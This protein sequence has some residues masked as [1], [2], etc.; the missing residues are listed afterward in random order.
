MTD[1]SSPEAK[2]LLRLDEELRSEADHVLAASGLGE[3]LQQ[4]GFSAVGS[5]AMRTMTWRDLDFER[6]DD[7]PDWGR[8]WELGAR[9]AKIS[10]VWR[11]SC[12]D[13]Y[14]QPNVIDQG[15]YWGLRM[16][17]P[18]GGPTWKV[19]LWT[20]REEEFASGS[21]NR[22]RWDGLLNRKTR[23]HILAIK[24]TVCRL[25]EYRRTILSVHIY[26]AVLD[27]G[28]RGIDDFNRWWRTRYG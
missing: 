13:A 1:P 12:V 28:V 18:T 20:G 24:E 2:R 15:L 16:C 8:H 25:P 3:V 22:A 4:E 7:A 11:F 21:P 26:E 17:D 19:D 14:R 9:L 10:W 27:C 5:Y 23:S 6:T